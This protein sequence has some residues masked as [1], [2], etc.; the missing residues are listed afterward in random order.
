M[1][2]VGAVSNII[3]SKLYVSRLFKIYPKDVASSIPGIL[4]II[5]CKK[6]LLYYCISSVIPSITPP[7]EP[8]PSIPPNPKPPSE[9]SAF[10]SISIAYKFENPF[11]IVGYPQNF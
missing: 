6:P 11:I 1:C 10:G 4:P 9:D 7:Y 3:R 5:S 2:P 8:S